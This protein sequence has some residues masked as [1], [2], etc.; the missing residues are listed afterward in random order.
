MSELPEGWIARVSSSTGRTY[1]VNTSTKKSQWDR[2]TASSEK[3]R[4]SHLL[5]KHADSRRP[6]SWR[7]KNITRS[8]EDAVCIINGYKDDIE[9]GKKTFEEL[10]SQFSDCSSARNGG[11]LGFF[12]RYQ[13]QK[14]FE[15]AAFALQVGELCG[16]VETDSGVHIIKRTA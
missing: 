4:C 6:S 11:D 1:Y 14:P 13:M 7:E 3:I 8:K 10:A 12:G 5:V 2:P 16:P 9:S 15:D